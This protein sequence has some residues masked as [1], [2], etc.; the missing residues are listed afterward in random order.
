MEAAMELRHLR[1][2]VAVAGSLTLAAEKRLRTAQPSL[3]RQIRDLE[4]EVGVQLM[5]RS[6]HGIELTAAGRA[7]LD[8]A[9]LALTQAE[10]AAEAARRAAQPVKPT[11]A[12]GFQ[13]GQEVDWLPRATSILC[14]ELPNIEIRVSSDHSTVLADDLQRGKLDITFLRWEQKPDLGIG[15]SRRSRSSWSCRATIRSLSA[16]PLIRTISSV[17]RSSGYRASR[18]YCVLPSMIICNDLE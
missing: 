1:Y 15:W 5:S 14:D 13:T 10:A 6:V 12:M 11:F 18:A 4:Y 2:F 9:R 3:S 17:K 16:R 8:H 7:F